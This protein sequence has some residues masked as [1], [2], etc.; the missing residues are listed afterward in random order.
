VSKDRWQIGCDII[1]LVTEGNNYTRER[2]K[3][4]NDARTAQG[5][6]PNLLGPIGS[7]LLPLSLCVVMHQ[8]K[9]YSVKYDTLEYLLTV[10]WPGYP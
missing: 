5:E 1:L 6:R 2:E 3:V 7:F 8:K 4:K 9:G 10:S